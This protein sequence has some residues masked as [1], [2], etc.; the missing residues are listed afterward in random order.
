[1]MPRRGLAG[2]AVVVM[3]LALGGAGARAQQPLPA[4]PEAHEHDESAGV[5]DIRAAP[6]VAQ[7]LFADLVCLCGGCK[8]LTLAACP[9][10]HAKEQRAKVMGL[11]QGKDVSSADKEEAVYKEVIQSFIK[12]AGGQHVLTVPLDVG[13]NRLMGIVPYA[14]IGLALLLVVI[15]SLRW[16]K[17]GKLGVTAGAGLPTGT[18]AADP[19]A[20][21][22]LTRNQREDL[23]DRLDDEL[24]E[25]D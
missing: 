4:E 16:V 10:A 21:A 15:V 6:H 2:V 8:R 19:K 17:R 23:E 12:E 22:D 5:D 3:V 18:R 1:M 13:F 25:I 14:V 9:C 7:R 24:R 11:L 20:T